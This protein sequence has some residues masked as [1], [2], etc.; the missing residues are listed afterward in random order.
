MTASDG[1]T[2]ELDRGTRWALASAGI[3]ILALFAAGLGY[4]ATR[5]VEH[6]SVALSFFGGMS[7]LLTP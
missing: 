2:A 6:L 4:V 3:A 1:V 7:M 5:S